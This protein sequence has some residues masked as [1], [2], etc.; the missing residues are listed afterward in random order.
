MDIAAAV[1]APEGGKLYRV[2][3]GHELDHVVMVDPASV[4]DEDF[5]LPGDHLSCPEELDL[6]LQR[7]QRSRLARTTRV[8]VL[9]AALSGRAVE[10]HRI[11]F[12]SLRRFLLRWEDFLRDLAS[13]RSLV[14]DGGVQALPQGSFAVRVTSSTCDLAYGAKAVRS[15]A[16]GV[17]DDSIRASLP[18][19][20]TR[21]SFTA[22][23]EALL[24]DG[25]E[26]RVDSASQTGR[27]VHGQLSSERLGRLRDRLR[28]RTERRITTQVR[29]QLESASVAQRTMALV[30]EDDGLVKIDVPREL[31]GEIRGKRIGSTYTLTVVRF[32]TLNP[33][34][35][36]VEVAFQLDIGT[37]SDEPDD[38]TEDDAAVSQVTS[39]GRRQEREV[40]VPGR[41]CRRW[42]K[43]VSATD[44][45]Q[46]GSG[47]VPYLRLTE[48]GNEIG[49]PDQ[50]FR[51]ELLGIQGWTRAPW[52][53]LRRFAEKADL[54]FVLFLP[55]C[56][57]T[58]RVLTVTHDPA[59][60]SANAQPATWIH[61]D[62]HL[63]EHLR[64]VDYR[65]CW[66][67]VERDEWDQLFIR[68]LRSKPDWHG[69]AQPNGV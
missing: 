4:P 66:V 38:E 11:G 49:D 31:V 56:K 7:E 1:R 8:E 59:R 60:R 45:Q 25:L 53:R 32:S 64:A 50:W 22:L 65:G 36:E 19:A 12:E 42:A 9:D 43:Q 63:L 41:V 57:P 37:P 55:E 33:F 40:I 39:P 61:W 21:R 54:S 69:K 14:W 46:A 23:A 3:I 24:D 13:S 27:V 67:S 5:P 58:V 26:V 47:G 20:E 44:A 17:E 52:G 6:V 18:S 15:L 35:D 28:E 16:D 48:S 51:T 68:F 29:G 62:N 34:G 2:R 10:Q 30:N